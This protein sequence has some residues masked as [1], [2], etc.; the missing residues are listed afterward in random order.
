MVNVSV[1]WDFA[2][3]RFSSQDPGSCSG[4]IMLQ[5]TLEGQR[6][7]TEVDEGIMIRPILDC[8]AGVL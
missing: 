3:C 1:L 2:C 5:V 8:R 4:W 7:V 6:K